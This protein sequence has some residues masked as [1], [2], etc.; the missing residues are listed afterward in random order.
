MQRNG[1]QASS[2][3]NAS[4]TAASSVNGSATIGAKIP[5]QRS[6]RPFSGHS[7]FMRTGWSG[8]SAPE[9]GG[10]LSVRKYA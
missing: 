2:R 1:I 6:T 10:Y 9:N 3:Q 7:A 4:R 5:R 8:R